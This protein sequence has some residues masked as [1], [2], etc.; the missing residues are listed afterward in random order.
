MSSS[1]SRRLLLQATGRQPSLPR[2]GAAI[3]GSAAQ[4]VLA[5]VRPDVGVSAYPFDLARVRLTASRWLENQN[6]TVSYL[7]FV[8]VDRL[9]YNQAR[10]RT[11]HYR[12]RGHIEHQPAST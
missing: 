5:P 11:S 9:L 10:A 12:R 4:A 6:R 1:I 2:P 8:D 3:G 7:R